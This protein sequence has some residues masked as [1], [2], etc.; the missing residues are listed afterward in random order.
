[1]QYNT[2][3]L[4]IWDTSNLGTSCATCI[5]IPTTGTGYNYDV[6]WEND[7]IFDD[8]GVT[9]IKQSNGK[10]LRLCFCFVKLSI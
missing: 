3:L 9:G 8:F 1:M 2:P 5:T 10:Y 6:D 4:S 7:G